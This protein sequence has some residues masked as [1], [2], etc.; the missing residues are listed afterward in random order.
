MIDLKP[1]LVRIR[2]FAV[3]TAS[4]RILDANPRRQ[5]V[6]IFNNGATTVYLTS[7]KEQAVASGIPNPPSA[8]YEN[9]NFNCTGEYFIIGTAGV[10]V[11]VEEDM[12]S[13]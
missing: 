9:Q 1:K 11:R 13:P 12:V 3:T 10:D 7:E 2:S 5:A 4:Q 6:L 8:N